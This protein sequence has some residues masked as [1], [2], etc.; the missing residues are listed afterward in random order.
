MFVLKDDF[1]GLN[2]LIPCIT[3]SQV[4]T[5]AIMEC[6]ALQGTPNIFVSD[7]ASYFIGE[8]MK[9]FTTRISVKHHLND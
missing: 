2:M 4:A 8:V 9:D 1:S 5:A 3:N 6:R 7:Q